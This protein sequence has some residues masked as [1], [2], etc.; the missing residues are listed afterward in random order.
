MSKSKSRGLIPPGRQVND[1]YAA[2]RRIEKA[3]GKGEERPFNR[4]ERRMLAKRV[5]RHG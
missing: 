2:Y 3:I 1:L 4:T 5:K